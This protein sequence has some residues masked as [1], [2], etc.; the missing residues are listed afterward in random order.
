MASLEDLTGQRFGHLVALFRV[1][2]GH[3]GRTRWMCRCDCGSNHLVLSTCL[4][5]GHV[6]SCG[7]NWNRGRRVKEIPSGS[8]FGHLTVIKSVGTK[9]LRYGG[10]KVINR[11]YFLCK[12]DCGNYKEISLSDLQVGVKTC[13]CGKRGRGAKHG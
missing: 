3:T 9:V 6:T 5:Q 2:N 11:Q 8:R 1:P 7:C 13:G 12:C 4:K 10:N